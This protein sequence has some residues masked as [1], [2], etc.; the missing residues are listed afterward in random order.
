[1]HMVWTFFGLVTF[2]CSL[3]VITIESEW[4]SISK[5]TYHRCFMPNRTQITSEDTASRLAGFLLKLY[6]AIPQFTTL[7]RSFIE[8]RYVGCVNSYSQ[9][10]QWF[11]REVTTITL[12]TAI[13]LTLY[14]HHPFALLLNVY[15]E[16]LI[17]SPNITDREYACQTTYLRS[18]SQ[19][20]YSYYSLTI[21]RIH[22]N[23]SPPSSWQPRE[24]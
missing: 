4:L 13:P 12:T 3:L 10:Y 11:H 24:R 19:H 14:W 2:P 5:R 9:R 6:F 1:M 22:F 16:L 8:S 23:I 20:L 18:Q 17:F 21:E 7:K 15:R